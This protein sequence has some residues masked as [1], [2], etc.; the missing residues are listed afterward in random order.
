MSNGTQVR[1][2]AQYAQPARMP[3]PKR[4]RAIPTRAVTGTRMAMRY[5]DTETGRMPDAAGYLW[6]ASAAKAINIS[7]ECHPLQ[8]P[9][10]RGRL[11]HTSIAVISDIVRAE[12]RS[13]CPDEGRPDPRHLRLDFF[14]RGQA[15]MK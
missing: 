1:V 7:F 6:A 2:A 5:L 10:S 9:H 12:L 8:R 14:S 11:C 15:S 4:T 13:A 3:M